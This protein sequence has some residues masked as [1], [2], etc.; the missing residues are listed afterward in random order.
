MASSQETPQNV[1]QGAVEGQ[2]ARL[3]S[4]SRPSFTR[5][6]YAAAFELA[7]LLD[8]GLSKE[9]TKTLME[10]CDAGVNPEALAAVVKELRDEAARIQPASAKQ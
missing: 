9:A 3:D 8:T 4:R 6:L 2:F 10:L 1:S 7:T 5:V